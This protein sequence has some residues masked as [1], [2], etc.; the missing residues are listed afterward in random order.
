MGRLRK[1]KVKNRRHTKKNDAKGSSKEVE[2]HSPSN[3]E[4]GEKIKNGDEETMTKENGG[5]ISEEEQP[6]EHNEEDAGHDK[7]PLVDAQGPESDMELDIIKK[8][9][10]IHEEYMEN[11]PNELEPKDNNNEDDGESDIDYSTNRGITIA[12]QR[13]GRILQYTMESHLVSILCFPCI[14][15]LAIII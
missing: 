11:L 15:C 7:E 9:I 10:N 13:K 3:E 4:I 8:P 14:I 6:V 5:G 1:N 12:T 2:L